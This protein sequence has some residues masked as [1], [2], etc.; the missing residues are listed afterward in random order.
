MNH[1]YDIVQIWHKSLQMLSTRM[2]Q[3]NGQMVMPA[4]ILNLL[5]FDR[6]IINF[7]DSSNEQESMLSN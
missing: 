3:S 7:Y 5:F 4:C 2:F 1:T 6:L